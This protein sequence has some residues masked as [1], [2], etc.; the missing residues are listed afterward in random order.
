[1]ITLVRYCGRFTQWTITEMGRMGIFLATALLY[2]FRPPLRGP[3]LIRRVHFIGT[4]SLLLIVFTGA[5]TGMVVAFQGYIALRRFGGEAFLGPGVGLSLIRELGPVLSALMITARAG[6]ALT[7]E[8]GIMRITEQI[9]A[10]DVMAIN[11]LKYLVV[12]ILLAALLTFPLL[13]GIF[14][15]VGIYGGYLIGVKLL[16]VSSGAYFS[17][18][19]SVVTSADI[20]NGFA[21]SLSFG[22]IVAWVCCFKGFYAERGAEG[23]SHAT[24]QAVVMSSVLILVWDYFLTSVLFR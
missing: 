11:P 1:V 7:A 6:S 9:D 17:Q 18:M 24:T 3:Q 16:G 10:L 22:L 2:I 8:L 19:S 14:V 20:W 4:R 12:P 13:S 23:V 15:V 5:F 21:K